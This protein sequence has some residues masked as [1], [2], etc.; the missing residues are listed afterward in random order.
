MGW[1]GTLGPVGP[2]WVRFGAVTGRHRGQLKLAEDDEVEERASRGRRAALIAGVLLVP[3]VLVS[4]IA[5]GLRDAPVSERPETA[6]TPVHN[7]ESAT[8]EIEPTFGK[9]VPPESDQQVAT[10][11]VPTRA[12]APVKKPR[13]TATPESTPSPTKRVR[14]PCPSG[15]DDVWWMRRWCERQ[16]GH[17]DR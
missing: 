8:P 5:V 1:P 15:W 11:A 3:V 2:V 4:V 16:G 10:K 17:G 13:K 12:P 6:G 7:A 9:Y 14:R